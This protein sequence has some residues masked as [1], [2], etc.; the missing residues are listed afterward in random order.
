MNFTG[1][2]GKQLE[3]LKEKPK[4]DKNNKP[5]VNNDKN[6]T[7]N[8]NKYLKLESECKEYTKIIV[9]V[10]GKV[11]KEIDN[12]EDIQN[13]NIKD[14]TEEV[15][16]TFGYEELGKSPDWRLEPSHDK[17]V[18]YLSATYSNFKNKG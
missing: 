14:L 3:N 6:N 2:F 15:L 12:K 10:F 17:V 11:I 18:A 8:I 5:G 9:K 4:D 16:Y 1:L 7:S 13:I